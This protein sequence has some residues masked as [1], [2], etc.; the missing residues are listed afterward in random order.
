MGK[1]IV[2]CF[3][4]TW[5]SPAEDGIPNAIETNVSRFFKSVDTSD[6]SSQVAWYN[7]GVGTEWYNKLTGGAMGSLLDKHIL[8]GYGWLVQQYNV[9]DDVYVL[10]FSRGAYTARSMVGMVRNCGLVKRG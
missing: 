8:G 4:G 3:D 9:G 1:R 2:L 6:P 7:A 5:N 10:G